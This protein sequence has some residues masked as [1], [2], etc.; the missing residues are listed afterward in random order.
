VSSTYLPSKRI[1]VLIAVIVVAG[2]GAWLITSDGSNSDGSALTSLQEKE[3]LQEVDSDDDGLSDWQEGLWGTD[4]EDPDSDGDGTE[5]GAEVAADRNPNE[6]G[7]G[8]QLATA[9]VS[10]QSSAS[11][12]VN[13]TTQTKRELLPQSL[14]LAI[15]RENGEDVSDGDIERIAE[16]VSGG[17]N[18][19]INLYT[20]DDLQIGEPASTPAEAR[21]YVRQV[22]TALNVETTG[23]QTN[24][25]AIVAGALQ[26]NEKGRLDFSS[27]IAI[28]QTIIANLLAIAV[29]PAYTASH[30]QIVNSLQSEKVALEMLETVTADPVKGVVAVREYKA[31]LA[32]GE[33]A[34]ETLAAQVNNTINE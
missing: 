27:Y 15:A 21:A 9:N 16:S 19:Q 4:P 23:Q 28:D 13:L 10:V 25:L 1:L 2:V 20:A 3:R 6:A 5:D 33:K 24:P 11:Q 22:I 30:L 14:I 34:V 29:P 17:I 7:P 31:A 18:T 32:D 26:N 8:D 12:S